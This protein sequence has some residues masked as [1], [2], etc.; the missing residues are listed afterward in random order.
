[1]QRVAEVIAAH[2]NHQIVGE[3]RLQKTIKLLQRVGLDT[4]YTYSLHFFGPFSEELQMDTQLLDQMGLIRESLEPGFGADAKHVFTADPNLA[5]AL[6]NLRDQI[7]QISNSSA[8]AL[9]LAATY[10]SYRQLGFDPQ[11][12][13]E[14]VRLKKRDQC[15][16][17]NEADALRLLQLLGLN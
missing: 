10:D 14:K 4:D 5:Q 12:S 7:N 17:Q 6:G 9:E 1:M 11:K 13:L 15:N 16:P 3:V 8:A 2:P